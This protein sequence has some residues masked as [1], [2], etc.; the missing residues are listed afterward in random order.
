[1]RRY[2]L[3]RLNEET[4]A[5]LPVEKKADWRSTKKN[6][7]TRASWR[8]KGRNGEGRWVVVSVVAADLATPLEVGLAA[9]AWVLD[10]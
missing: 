8:V 1:M 10:E 4:D 2:T 3:S 9:V 6:N 5:T 7:A